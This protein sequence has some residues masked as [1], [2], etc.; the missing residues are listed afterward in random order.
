AM[1]WAAV[2]GIIDEQD[3][4]LYYI[5]A[6]HPWVAVYRGGSAFF[7][8]N[9]LSLHKLGMPENK[10]TFRVK[11]FK[12]ESGDKVF[13]GSDGRDDI[14]L[15]KD[16]HGNTSINTD[17]KLFLRV[18]EKA[19]GELGGIVD[20][21]KS[22]GSITDDLS[23]VRIE[24]D[25]KDFKRLDKSERKRI[26]EK[27]LVNN[28]NQDI[29]KVKKGYE[30]NPHRLDLLYEL[31]FLSAHRQDWQIAAEFA[32]KFVALDASDKAIVYLAAQALK[33]S[34]KGDVGILKRA[35][36][37]AE[38]LLLRVPNDVNVILNLADIERYLGRHEKMQNLLLAAKA[39]DP[40]NKTLVKF[41]ID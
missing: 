38:R 3:G 33:L 13:S 1:L 30:E 31:A 18:I 37:Y 24:F 27:I 17:E 22:L 34:A 10:E 19:H 5:N 29:E 9:E 32:E 4:L 6:E 7:I 23:L 40:T 21:L 16:Q 35:A 12:L 8:E 41:R 25:P 39:I 11:T 2:I 14:A 36:D 28:K 26:Q 20:E 15:G